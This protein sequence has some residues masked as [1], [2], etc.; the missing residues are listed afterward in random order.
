L[1][2]LLKDLVEQGKTAAVFNQWEPSKYRLMTVEDESKK[3]EEEAKKKAETKEDTKVDDAPVVTMSESDESHVQPEMEGNGSTSFTFNPTDYKSSK[4]DD[5]QIEITIDIVAQLMQGLFH[6]TQLGKDFL[7]QDG[8]KLVLDIYGS[9]SLRNSFATSATAERLHIVLRHLAEASLSKVLNGIIESVRGVMDTCRGLW[10][11][12]MQT[13][14]LSPLIPALSKS[15]LSRYRTLLTLYSLRRRRR[16]ECRL[17]APCAPEQSAQRTLQPLHYR[18]FLSRQGRI[19]LP[20]GSWRIFR[21]DFLA[22]SGTVAP[23]LHLGKH[24]SQDEGCILQ[25]QQ[26][27]RKEGGRGAV[28]GRHLLSCHRTVR[29][30]RGVAGDLDGCCKTG[31]RS[32]QFQC[33]QGDRAQHTRYA[34]AILPRC[35]GP[36]IPLILLTISSGVIKMLLFRRAEPSHKIQAVPTAN[37]LALMIKDYLEVLPKPK[38]KSG[39]NFLSIWLTLL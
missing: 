2:T 9:P 25:D 14:Y 22:G 28:Y 7:A 10:D 37:A 26:R 38:G 23:C 36:L 20:S 17:Q 13:S 31:Y 8:L 29:A 12:G 30:R 34:H 24:P 32:A 16:E 4:K 21:I 3:A 1:S 11:S 27:G 39:W 6:N 18:R 5:N 15:A 35:V 33:H 19:V